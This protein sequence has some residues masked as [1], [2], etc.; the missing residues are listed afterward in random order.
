MEKLPCA[1]YS[2]RV[3]DSISVKSAFSCEEKTQVFCVCL[4][5]CFFNKEIDD[6]TEIG[7]FQ[8]GYR[9]LAPLL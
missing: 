1:T 7:L 6:T 3:G 8:V 4:F 2:F 9:A 5:V